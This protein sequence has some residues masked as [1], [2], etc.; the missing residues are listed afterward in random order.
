MKG[1]LPLATIHGVT[2][3]IFDSCHLQDHILP[4]ILDE[5]HVEDTLFIVLEEDFRFCK[6]GGE[7]IA[8]DPALKKV[9]I[10]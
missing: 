5:R 4:Y 2:Q 8:P 7:P 10:G 1:W 3:Y 9:R 6:E